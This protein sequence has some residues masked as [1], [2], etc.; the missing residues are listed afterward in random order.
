MAHQPARYTESIGLKVTAEQYQTLTQLA[1]IN[2]KPIAEWC[3]DTLVAVAGCGRPSPAEF[4]LLAEIT[5]TQAIVID[6]LCTVGKEGKLTT[7]KAQQ[8]VEAAHDNKYREALEVLRV[9]HT[10]ASKL[11]LQ[12]P[13]QGERRGKGE[14]HE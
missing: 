8:I 1:G 6:L 13:T 10:Q 9:A 3:R 2:S 5:A 14:R 12:V 7:Q 11:R 4:G